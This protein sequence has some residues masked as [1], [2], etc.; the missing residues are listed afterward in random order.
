MIDQEN[1]DSFEAV[2]QRQWNVIRRRYGVGVIAHK[3]DRSAT[4]KVL[5]RRY[6]GRTT[7]SQRRQAGRSVVAATWRVIAIYWRHATFDM[8]DK[9]CIFTEQRT[10]WPK[11]EATLFCCLHLLTL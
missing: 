9:I 11:S 3:N 4:T 2:G 5:R 1:S 8:S 7:I 10:R 6:D